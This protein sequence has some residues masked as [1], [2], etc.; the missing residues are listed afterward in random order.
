MKKTIL[1]FIF[2]FG[3]ISLSYGVTTG[4]NY[5]ETII[6]SL[7]L[8]DS[9]I[10]DGFIYGKIPDFAKTV[11]KENP[12]NMDRTAINRLA[13]N[14][15]PDGNS[16]SIKALHVSILARKNIPYGDDIVYYVLVFNDSTSANKEITKLNEYTK[17][18]KD[19]AVVV[20]KDNVAVFIHVD[21]AE[22]F[23]YLYNFAK[24]A[25]TTLDI[26]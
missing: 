26:Q 2:M 12:W 14:I 24:K 4:E 20:S 1:V 6:E 3:I 25:K 5:D 19:R 13:K 11:L 7:K 10:P 8:A 17:F 23:N 15:Y 22:D 18:N 21:D 9:D 16:N